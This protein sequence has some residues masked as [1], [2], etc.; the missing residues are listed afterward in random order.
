VIVIVFFITCILIVIYPSSLISVVF[1][2]KY[3][4]L[5]AGLFG[6]LTSGLFLYLLSINLFSSKI[7]LVINN[8]GILNNTDYVNIGL[9]KWTDILEIK[10][11]E[12]GKGKYLLL[13]LKNEKTYIENTGN[14]FSK[15]LL[16]YNRLQYNTIVHI[17]YKFLESSFEELENILQN[18]V[19]EFGNGKDGNGTD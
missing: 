15:L 16:Y 9:I 14:Y 7:G 17:N 11:K 1:R 13:N 2:S 4:I 8:Q 19:N 5:V 3:I 18:G 12:F 6:A 10:I